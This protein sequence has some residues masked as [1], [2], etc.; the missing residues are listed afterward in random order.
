MEQNGIGDVKYFMLLK[1]EATS[2]R[3]VF[4]LARKSD[5]EEK[6]SDFISFIENSTEI[7]IKRIRCDNGTE[8][9]NEHVQ[10]TLI[11]RGIVLERIAPYTP[12]QNGLIERDNRTIQESARTM[13]L[14][15]GLDK[16]LWPFERRYTF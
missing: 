9:I 4:L 6:L 16:M 3:S 13:L 15:S 7:S 1:D 2:F 5:V 12:E 11:K 14:S 10:K 8:F